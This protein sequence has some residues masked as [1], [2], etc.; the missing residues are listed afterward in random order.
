MEDMLELSNEPQSDTIHRSFSAF[1]HQTAASLPQSSIRRG[2][3]ATFEVQI[4]FRQHTSWQGIL[5]WLDEHRQ[6][7]FRSVLELILLMD[8]ALRDLEGRDAS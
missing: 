3:Q 5:L 8:S 6:Q 1:L 2:Q 4:L 7:S